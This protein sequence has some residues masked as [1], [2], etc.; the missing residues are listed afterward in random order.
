MGKIFSVFKNLLESDNKQKIK[1]SDKFVDLSKEKENIDEYEGKDNNFENIRIYLYGNNLEHIYKNNK[2]YKTIITKKILG[3]DYYYFKDN[4]INFEYLIFDGEIS[5]EK[6]EAISL[7]LKEDYLNKQFYDIII[8]SIDSLEDEST[9]MFISHFQSS[10]SQKIRQPFILFLTQKEEKPNIKCLYSHI[11]NKYFDKRNLAAIKFPY[12]DFSKITNY[13]SEKISYY[14]GYGDLYDKNET[15]VEYLFNILICGISGVGKSTFVNMFQHSKRSKEGEG[16]SVTDKIIRFTHPKYPIGVYDTPGFENEQTVNKV[17]ELLEK[18]NKIL[19]DERK[20]I[21]LVLYFLPYSDRIFL[22]MEKTI[23]NY[24]VKLDCYIIFV[25]NKVVDDLNGDDYL[26]YS[27]TF[28][29]EIKK[30]YAKYTHK[31]RVVPVNLYHAYKNGKLV[32]KAFGLDKLFFEMYTIFKSEKID[33]EN[34]DKIDS[35]HGLFDFLS[36]NQLYTQFKD[37]NDLILTLKTKASNYIIYYS[38]TFLYNMNKEKDIKEM[39]KKIYNLYYDE[40]EDCENFIESIIKKEFS[41]EQINNLYDDFF[42]NIDFLK[43]LDKIKSFS[44]FKSIHDK[45]TIIK[46]NYCMK[47][48]EEKFSHDPNLFIKDNK[49]NLTIIKKCCSS[50]NQAIDSFKIIS[51]EFTEIYNLLEQRDISNKKNNTTDLQNDQELKYISL[52]IEDGNNDISSNKM[53]FNNDNW[54]ELFFE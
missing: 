23:L 1:A 34:I 47:K 52:K 12:E 53:E 37:K 44:F 51:N 20:K 26:R 4:S 46:G 48:L 9:K 13:I 6:N 39:I 7:L 14:N 8:L 40:D 30:S 18:Y 27:E 17:K 28:E 33:L 16:N 54:W 35:I 19:K 43:N 49:P 25:I 31:F 38:R 50:L 21:N 42:K 36:K 45:E 32:K 3:S 2:I 22:E 15:N 10:T 5:K 41:Y 29:D 11:T 24:L